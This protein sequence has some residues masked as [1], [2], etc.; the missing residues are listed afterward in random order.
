[1]GYDSQL[2]FVSS[3]LSNLHKF[4]S[5]RNGSLDQ[6][7]VPTLLHLLVIES[8]LYPN[9]NLMDVMKGPKAKFV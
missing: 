6:P 8:F 1:M 7:K 4:S 5:P 9:F 3:T 2:S